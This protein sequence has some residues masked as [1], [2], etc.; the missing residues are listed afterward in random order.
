[1]NTKVGKDVRIRNVGRYCL[2]EES[3]DS[4]KRREDFSMGGNMVL[5]SKRLPH[6]NI[7]KGIWISPNGQTKIKLLPE[8]LLK[9]FRSWRHLNAIRTIIG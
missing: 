2:H 3:N 9:D 8:I 7:R 4:G 6:K 5:S 1:M